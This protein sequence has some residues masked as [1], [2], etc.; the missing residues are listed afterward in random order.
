M[1][2]P[3]AVA[4]SPSRSGTHTPA[5]GNNQI[6]I[7]TSSSASQSG[8][9]GTGVAIGATVGVALV[10]AAITV[11][12]VQRKR[13]MVEE[14]Q[15]KKTRPMVL[16][17]SPANGAHGKGLVTPRDKVLA[18]DGDGKK[19]VS[20][21]AAAARGRSSAV[22]PTSTPSKSP[23]KAFDD[24]RRATSPNTRQERDR[25]RS[26]SK[27][28]KDR[29]RSSSK[30][31]KDR[32]R[33]SSKDDKH[34]HRSSSK[35]E[36]DHPAVTANAAA[37]P[38]LNVPSPR[39]PDVAVALPTV[40]SSPRASRKDT[41]RKSGDARPAEAASS[42][43]RRSSSSRGDR[44]DKRSGKDDKPASSRADKRSSSSKPVKDRKHGERE[45]SKDKDGGRKQSK[46]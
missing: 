20:A 38:D 35:D 43:R 22:L 16:T 39:V 2:S 34:R 41:S 37:A 18:R 46:K 19:P 28:D 17:K 31:D 33:S 3:S 30:D 25:H 36:Q 7:P 5:S 8:L 44:G 4:P 12:L 40:P 1:P 9:D 45:K 11:F 21:T 6:V 24:V 10:G 32:H 27:D 42:S 23:A 29:H 15:L 13:R 26:S 14:A